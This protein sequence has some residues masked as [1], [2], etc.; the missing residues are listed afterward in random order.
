MTEHLL[1]LS[2]ASG[3][4]ERVGALLQRFLARQPDVAKQ[5]IIQLGESTS[6]PALLHPE[7]D[8]A[9]DRAAKVCQSAPMQKTASS[10]ACASLPEDHPTAAESSQHFSS[11]SAEVRP[12][13][14]LET[15]IR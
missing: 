13:M 8:G 5:A 6:L 15:Q 3:F 7:Q 4:P 9:K 14:P 10:M 12:A 1:N 2:A 11:P